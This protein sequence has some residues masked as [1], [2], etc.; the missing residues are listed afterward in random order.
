MSDE[1][2]SPEQPAPEP[3]FDRKV[4]GMKV[5]VSGW[6][7]LKAQ[8]EDRGG[9]KYESAE[10]GR[11]VSVEAPNAPGTADKL[12]AGLSK[13]LKAKLPAALDDAVNLMLP[14]GRRK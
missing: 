11:S 3:V 10:V 2:K 5:T 8:M 1:K 4:E 12:E 6:M 13:W 9:R 7:T 14:P